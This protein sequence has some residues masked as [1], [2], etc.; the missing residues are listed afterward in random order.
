MKKGNS[1]LP[2]Q[3]G[4]RS[5][6]FYGVRLG[7]WEA[8]MRSFPSYFKDSL[9]YPVEMVNWGDVQEFINKL[10]ERTGNQFRLPTEEEWEYACRSGTTGERY[11]DLDAIA[12][13]DGNS[14]S[15]THPVGQKRP[16]ARG[17]YDMLGNVWEWCQDLYK[18]D[19][20]NSSWDNLLGPS[21][22]AFRVSRGGS[23]F[24]DSRDIRAALRVNYKLS[25]R[26]YNLGFRLARTK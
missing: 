22:G 6:Y 11:G 19:Y 13:N 21:F 4:R 14:G 10:N 1:H 17:L 9:Q 12:W 26:F 7:E 18:G 25:R 16:N 20:Y 5:D 24:G 15:S 2:V 3:D 23:C 8:V